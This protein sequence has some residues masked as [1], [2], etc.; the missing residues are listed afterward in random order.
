MNDEYIKIGLRDESVFIKECR[1]RWDHK[2]AMRLH[3]SLDGSTY[4]GSKLLCFTK[5]N[6][7]PQRIERVSF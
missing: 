3:H 7:F 5:N 1:V 2:Q 4:L 6:C